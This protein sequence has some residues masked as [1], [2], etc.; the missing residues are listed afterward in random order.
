LC[1]AFKVLCRDP[2]HEWN[3]SSACYQLGA[4]RQKCMQ[5]DFPS[6]EMT[7]GCAS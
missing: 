2:E 5:Q 3:A 4:C 6:G 7:Q 1:L